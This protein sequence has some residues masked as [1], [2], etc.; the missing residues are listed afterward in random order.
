MPSWCSTPRLAGRGRGRGTP[1]AN[2]CCGVDIDPG[3]LHELDVDT[4]ADRHATLGP[5]I[6][7]V[8][9]RQGERLLLAR[10]HG[11][12]TLDRDLERAEESLTE[13]ARVP[14]DRDG[15]RFNDARCDPGGRLW[16]GTMAMDKSG[17]FGALIASIPTPACTRCAPAWG[18]RTGSVG[19]LTARACTTSTR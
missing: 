5:T 15:I 7:A 12:S 17:P 8:A 19:A 14:V 4:G 13:L 2:V 11:F 9:L 3:E 10:N 18:Y 1:H 6:G 16:G